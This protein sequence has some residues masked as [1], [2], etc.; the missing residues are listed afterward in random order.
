MDDGI[1]GSKGKGA[2]D[3]L[4]KISEGAVAGILDLD[5]RNTDL[6][7]EF[8]TGVSDGEGSDRA[9]DLILRAAGHLGRTV[10]QGT[11]IRHRIRE[12]HGFQFAAGSSPDGDVAVLVLVQAPV[13]FIRSPDGAA[14][15]I[16][17][18]S[19]PDG[20]AERQDCIAGNI[21]TGRNRT[22]VCLGIFCDCH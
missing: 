20:I 18:S 19:H 10:Q 14:V 8:V 6:P 7:I 4:I 12:L 17:G 3:R 22:V 5:R 21:I 11:I 13:L 9:A 15:R 1:L 16:P 2:L